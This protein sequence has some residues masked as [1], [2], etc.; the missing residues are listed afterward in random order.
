MAAPKPC[1]QGGVGREYCEEGGG[2]GREL[3]L[4]WLH[5]SQGGARREHCK[6]GGR[7]L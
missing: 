3:E 1:P 2:G 5:S 6:E 7:G 4:L